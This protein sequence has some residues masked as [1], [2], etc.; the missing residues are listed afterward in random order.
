MKLRAN[1]LSGGV[2][3]SHWRDIKHWHWKNFKPSEFASKSNG[4][5]YWHIKTFDAIQ[6]AREILGKPVYIN[7]AHRDWLYNI[8]V[9]GAPRSAH[10]FIALDIST[11]GHNRAEVYN[12]LT[13]AGFK[14]FGFYKTFIHADMRPNRRWFGSVAA[15]AVWQPIL[16]MG[17]PEIA[18]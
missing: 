3:Y 15:K 4:E 8:A 6:R 2:L 13:E 18:L 1:P 7:S 5:F 14:S 12:A 9:G 16:S 10:L 17:T 11:R